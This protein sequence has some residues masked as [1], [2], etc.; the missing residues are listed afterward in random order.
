M[1]WCVMSFALRAGDRIGRVVD[2]YAVEA[3]L[4]KGGFGAVYR[5]RHVVLGRPVAL[6]VLHAGAASA[7]PTSVERF[8]REAKA[9]SAIGSPSI[10]QVLDAGISPEGDP[11]L[12][13]ELLDGEDLAKRLERR[14]R[15]EEREVRGLGLEMLDALAA[16]HAA[17]IVH[18]DLKPANVFLARDALGAERVKLLDFGISKI[19]SDRARVLTQSNE[20]L[21]TPLYMAPEQLSDVREADARADLWSWGA[22]AFEMAS[23]RRPYEASNVQELIAKRLTEPPRSIAEVAP[24][25]APDLRAAIDAALSLDPARRGASA[26]AVAAA[27]RG[28]ALPRTAE[29]PA[30]VAPT[31][32]KTPRPPAPLASAPLASALVA[33]DPVGSVPS[34]AP[35]PPGSV[36][37]VAPPTARRSPLALI[38]VV[39]APIALASACV[40]AAAAYVGLRATS[41]AAH[42]PVAPRDAPRPERDDDLERAF[43]IAEGILGESWGAAPPPT[44]AP[45]TDTTIREVTTGEIDRAAVAAWIERAR[46]T[47]ASC[48]RAG[49]AEAV[50]IEL[51]VQSGRTFA[52]PAPLRAQSDPAVAACVAQRFADA[53]P[54]GAANG[55]V[56]LD[57]ALPAR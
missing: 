48:A 17:G 21:G 25:L 19:T 8:L 28:H 26:R 30:A 33:P 40:I 23:G 55:V 34:G 2:R 31:A 49:V 43:G 47:L 7:S 20:I 27:L 54:A 53:S 56:T 44:A 15:L 24:A 29:T 22:I 45:A 3:L 51:V 37:A 46:P 13:M 42:T 5:A 16:A 6:K 50:E 9:A 52:Q 35:A 32:A 4:G 12:A 39:L 14:G 18:R 10:I 38:A 36:P 11:F 41:R 57:V 1:L